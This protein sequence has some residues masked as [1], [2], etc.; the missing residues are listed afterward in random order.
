M[1]GTGRRIFLLHALS[2]LFSALLLV[3]LVHGGVT[4]LLE[5]QTADVVE[6]ELRGLVDEYALGGP[7]F[8]RDAIAR[9]S[10]T[11]GQSD[12]VYLL[13]SRSGR[14]I[15]G[16]LSQFPAIETD[17]RWQR[18][19]LLR[20]DLDR[21][22]W[23][24]GRA[25]TLDNGG[26]LFVGRDLR[27]QR[28]FRSL[29]M[30]LSV[31][32]L[33]VFLA[34]GSVGGFM[35]SRS[36]LSRV[37]QIEGVAAGI[38]AGDLSR[39][40]PETGGDD[41]FDRL[42]SSL[43]QML[44]AN[45]SLIDELRTVTDSLSHDMRTPLA[46]AQTLIEQ[47]D[48]DSSVD[49][50]VQIRDSALEE[51]AHIQAVFTSLIDLSRLESGVSNDQ[52]EAFDLAALTHGVAEL[53]RPSIEDQ[54][55]T[56]SVESADAIAVVGHEQFLARALSNLLDNSMKF[57]PRGGDITIYLSDLGETVDLVVRD[58]GPGISDLDW[59][60]ALS[61][62]GRLDTARTSPGS[63]LGLSL[64]ATIMRIHGAEIVRDWS[65]GRFGVRM[66][67]RNRPA[68]AG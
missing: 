66:I 19:E 41:E 4:R 64:V 39:R 51:L 60:T 40:A 11:D 29:L 12:H 15:A 42:A 27:E 56:L 25:F 38:R 33:I 58:D 57:S 49:E 36:I 65:T 43:N 2:A 9:R 20:T 48:L 68:E 50:R 52:F 23:V 6:A 32:L 26:R 59:P 47:M 1:S 55:L 63:G 53:Y 22:V 61:R 14:P 3:G 62:F 44:R 10:S 18:V 28:E 34:T 17:G 35:V 13:I 16:N 46:R 21:S 7:S 37:R 31:G 30:L 24:G 54:G 67:F 8:L 5:G 45:E